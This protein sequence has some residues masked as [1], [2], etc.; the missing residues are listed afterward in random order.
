MPN[1]ISAY[2]PSTYALPEKTSHS[3]NLSYAFNTGILKY[4]EKDLITN[5]TQ[6]YVLNIPSALTGGNNL[7]SFFSVTGFKNYEF[8][9]FSNAPY[10]YDYR[11]IFYNCKE[12]EEIPTFY[13]SNLTNTAFGMEYSFGSCIKLTHIPK[14][15]FDLTTLPTR[16]TSVNLTKTFI[17]CNSLS[18]I[19]EGIQFNKNITVYYSNTFNGCSNLSSIDNNNL[20]ENTNTQK[21]IYS[22]M[23]SNCSNLTTISDDVKLPS[24]FITADGMFSNCSRLTHVPSGFFA[25]KQYISAN[26]NKINISNI[27][28]NCKNITGIIDINDIYNNPLFSTTANKAFYNCINIENYNNPVTCGDITYLAIPDSW[29]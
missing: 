20:F 5:S 11:Y 22:Y 24:S 9:S 8:I 12:L 4:L 19:P 10:V 15:K 29:K 28:Y 14:N 3:I 17:N 27:F 2:I 25:E 21:S 23:F 6:E 26:T 18:A 16:I 7:I 1:T 13:F